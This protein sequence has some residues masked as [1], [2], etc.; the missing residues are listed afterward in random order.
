MVCRPR[1][2]C[3]PKSW[4]LETA[5][6]HSGKRESRTLKGFILACFRNRSHRHLGWLAIEER[7]G[8]EPSGTFEPIVFK[9]IAI[10]HSAIAPKH[11]L[12]ET[13]G[14]EPRGTFEPFD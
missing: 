7:E 9:T 8:F 11:S 3:V 4:G 13:L 6:F 14:F 2:R 10:D 12:A 1:A 5:S